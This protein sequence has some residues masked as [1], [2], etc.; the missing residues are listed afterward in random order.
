MNH[1]LTDLCKELSIP[2]PQGS[3]YLKGDYFYKAFGE[4]D[5]KPLWNG[6]TPTSFVIGLIVNGIELKYPFTTEDFKK[7]IK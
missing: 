2:I 1:I 7:E 5:I 6:Q 3:D 4:N